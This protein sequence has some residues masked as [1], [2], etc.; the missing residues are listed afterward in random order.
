[1]A[2]EFA[3]AE[4]DS[5]LL[6]ITSRG[7]TMRIILAASLVMVSVTGCMP[8]QEAAPAVDPQ[9]AVNCQEATPLEVAGLFDRW[10]AA[11]Q[12]GDAGKVADLYTADAILLPTVSNT[13]RT[14]R[15]GRLDYFEHFLARQ[16]AGRIDS[17]TTSSSCNK[18]VDSGLYTFTFGDTGEEVKARFTYTYRF[19]EGQWLISSHHSSVFPEAS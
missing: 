3:A 4:I 13:A 5:A 9:A 7:D 14:D 15:A 18:V 1:M 10:N 8:A 17:R 19:S 11:V 12:S 16:P 2:I 6:S